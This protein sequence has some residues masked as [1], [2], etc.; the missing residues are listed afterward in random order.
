MSRTP[1]VP[2]WTCTRITCICQS[3]PR[4]AQLEFILPARCTDAHGSWSKEDNQ[5]EQMLKKER[6]TS[7]STR[8]NRRNS[9]F[10]RNKWG[11][12]IYVQLLKEKQVLVMKQAESGREARLRCRKSPGYQSTAAHSP[13]LPHFSLPG[14][15]TVSIAV[16]PRTLLGCRQPLAP[17]PHR[18]LPHDWLL[19]PSTAMQVRYGISPPTTPF[20]PKQH[21]SPLWLLFIIIFFFF[22]PNNVSAFWSK[23][24]AQI[25]IYMFFI[26]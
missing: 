23:T 14:R 12:R 9:K 17:P 25:Y 21:F 15:L 18:Q 10:K 22:F 6:K 3:C 2:H 16:W 19:E 24:W 1:A 4:P 5:R 20:Q 11:A 26:F 13:I 7:S 8:R